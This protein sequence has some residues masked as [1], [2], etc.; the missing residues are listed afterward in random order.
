MHQVKTLLQRLRWRS[1]SFST[2]DVNASFSTMSPRDIFSLYF[3]ERAAMVTDSLAR[4]M[5]E[6]K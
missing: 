1:V 3:S 6:K 5:D 2:A 4:R